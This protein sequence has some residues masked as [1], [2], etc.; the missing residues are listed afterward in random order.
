MAIIDL[1]NIARVI[2]FARRTCRKRPGLPAGAILGEGDAGKVIWPTPTLKRAGHVFCLAAS[3]SGKSVMMASGL[4]DQL[5]ADPS[6]ATLVIDPKADLVKNV[7]SALAVRAP[8]RLADVVLLD[9]FRVVAAG[10]APFAFNLCR[11]PRTASTPAGVRAL[12]LADIV[13]KASTATTAVKV[14]SGHRQL[15]VLR[16]VLH[17]AITI[18]D[19]RA[20]L[21]LALD[22]LVDDGGLHRLA[23]LTTAP[24]PRAF[25]LGAK[26]ATEL[27]ASCA[28]RLRTALAM[29]QGISSMLT[30]ESCLRFDE[31]IG[32]GKICLL[33]LGRPP[34][35]LT[36]LQQFFASMFALV[37]VSHLMERP[38][39]FI[40]HPAVLVAD[41]AQQI[42]SV[43][44]GG[45]GEHVLCTGR[46]RAVSLTL[47]SQ[48]TTAFRREAPGLLDLI[49]ANAPL[50]IVGRLAPDDAQ[51]FARAVAP[52]EGVNESAGRLRQRFAGMVSNLPDREFVALRPGSR[53]RFVSREVDVGA[54]EEALREVDYS[55]LA[56]RAEVPVR[57]ERLRLSDFGVTS[58]PSTGAAAPSPWG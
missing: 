36:A 50:Q 38:S 40:G 12:Q 11:L 43:L 21:L 7:V 18:D 58:A 6:M 5:L 14:G 55:A 41:E 4:V 44:G 8:E 13:S 54:W 3:G 28:S 10:H 20:H 9:P 35:G 25:L 1:S 33:D 16:N 26:I 15:D 51:V 39:P 53:S 56:A 17:A 32:P 24:E 57:S 47:L 42:V 45:L 34:G 31:L 27:A 2:G 52:S 49:A 48:A 22:A 37:A 19:P 29:T 46:S 23:E 30:A